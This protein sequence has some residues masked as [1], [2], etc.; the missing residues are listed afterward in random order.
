MRAY[1]RKLNQD[2]ELWSICGLLHDFDYE[3]YPEPDP[4]A[5]TGHPF[6]GEKILREH[7]YSEEIIQAIQGHA[8]YS[9]VPRDAAAAKCLFAVDE[10]CGFVMACAY[11]RPD[12]FATMTP[13]SVE[14]NLR[15]KGFAAKINRAE[16]D[17]GVAEL[18][19]DP[20][21]P[22]GAGRAEHIRLVIE[23]MG[24]I[25]SELGF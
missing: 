9:G 16:I 2:G 22:L 10:L 21:T 19:I 24:G 12:R 25:A 15:K 14:K 17:Q 7:S 11:M 23:A 18:G 4:V 1:A 3:K 20:S 6:E 8:T 5:R 13:E